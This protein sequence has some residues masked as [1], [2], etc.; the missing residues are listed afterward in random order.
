MA[1]GSKTVLRFVIIALMCFA[2]CSGLGRI[3]EIALEKGRSQTQAHFIAG[4][5]ASSNEGSLSI[6]SVDDLVEQQV[7]DIDEMEAFEEAGWIFRL[8]GV[9]NRFVAAKVSDG[10]VYAVSRN[11]EW[12]CSNQVDFAGWLLGPQVSEE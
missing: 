4:I 2:A 11:G 1:G 7:A 3:A 6:R 5:I 10:Y 9:G 8:N 12:S